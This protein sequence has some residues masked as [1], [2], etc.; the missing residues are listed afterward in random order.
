MV[1]QEG[2]GKPSAFAVV[3]VEAKMRKGRPC[4]WRMFGKGLSSS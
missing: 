4:D 2:R 3:S 1:K